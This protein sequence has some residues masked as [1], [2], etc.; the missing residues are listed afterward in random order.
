MLVAFYV[1]GK[2][3]MEQLV[4]LLRSWHIYGLHL[5][6]FCASS[7][8]GGCLENFGATAHILSAILAR[9]GGELP[10]SGFYEHKPNK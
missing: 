9:G 2:E 7:L 6:F 10:I 8:K 1:L 4:F 3:S 5:P